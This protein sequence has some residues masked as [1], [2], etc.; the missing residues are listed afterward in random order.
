MPYLIVSINYRMLEKLALC[1][2]QL[3]KLPDSI[4]RLTSLKELNL[5]N[6]KLAELPLTICKLTTLGSIYIALY[7]LSYL[8]TL[9]SF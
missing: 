5:V 3:V 2:N 4:G 1:N 7:C 8:N 9:N 6:N